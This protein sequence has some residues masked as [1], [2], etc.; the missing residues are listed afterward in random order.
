[1]NYRFWRRA[2]LAATT[3]LVADPVAA[4]ALSDAPASESADEITVTALRESNASITGSDVTALRYPQSV[5]TIDAEAIERLG[6]TRLNDVIDLAGGVARQVDFGGLWDKYSIRGFA[7]DE[8]SGPDILINRFGSNLG[9][10]A[11]VD[12]ATVE[13]FEFL[14]GSAAALSGR[15]EPGGSLNIVTKAPTEDL[16]ASASLSYGRWNALRATADLSGPI[17]GNLA[18]RLIGVVEDKDSFRKTVHSNRELIAPSFSFTPSDRLRF[19]YQAEYMR[20]RTPLDRG[21]VGIG[22]DARAMD[23][24][25]FLG[26]PG[27]GPMDQQMFWQQGSV[28]AA[29]TDAISLEGGLSYRNGSLEGFQTQADFGGRGVQPDGRTIGRVRRFYDI[30]W[31]DFSGR[32]E[33]T[34]KAETFGLSHDL[35][36]G[37]DRVRHGMDKLMLQARG[38]VAAP[39]LTI[40][41]FDP[42]YGKTTSALGPLQ[43]MR[44]TFRSESIYAQDLITLGNFTLLLGARWNSFRETVINRNTANLRLDT[45]DRGITPRAALTWAVLPQLSLYTSWGRSLRLNPSD[46]ISTF[47][48]EK[49]E[50]AEI[51]LK[52]SVL[53]GALTGQAALFDMTKRNVLNPNATDPFVKT[54][55]GQQRSRG[56][57]TE[58]TLNLDRRTF[59]TGTYTY[60]DAIV[61]NDQNAALIGTRLSNVPDHLA[62]IYASHDFGLVV[63]GAGANHVGQR[64][65]DP[66]A[67]GYKLPAYTIARADV[68]VPLNEHFKLRLD[69]DNIFD[70]Y[71]ISSSFANVWTA[72]GA[73]RSWRVTVTGRF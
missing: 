42:V 28:F 13:R 32:V 49:S 67:T 30:D 24:T 71:Y 18:G 19:L 61:K 26:E 29:L 66:Y 57:E 9:F 39:I 47:D 46:G 65:G 63:I 40:D 25:T 60:I 70:D 53:G 69:V 1:M 55:I 21:V 34:A 7:G 72:P 51:G 10:N 59:V 35:R 31:N 36:I 23:R 52:Y 15:G 3:A 68:T 56:V 44:I 2:M 41:A 20:N 5:R 45:V 54:Q 37:V 43:N 62:A 4:Q 64:N 27:D 8:N 6:A 17:T 50:S 12:V 73:P 14:K 58:L 33:L 38:T 22:N 11:P 16:Q 48:A